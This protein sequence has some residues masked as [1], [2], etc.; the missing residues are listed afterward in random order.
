M[1]ITQDYRVKGN[2]FRLRTFFLVR[3][4]V[5]FLFFP[6]EETHISC[7]HQLWSWVT[8]LMRQT[9]SR[10]QPIYRLEHCSQDHQCLSGESVTCHSRYSDI[11][12]TYPDFPWLLSSKG[13]L[14][15]L[16]VF[17]FALQHKHMYLFVDRICQHLVCFH[18]SWE[19]PG[20]SCIV[21]PIKLKWGTCG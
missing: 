12:L 8:G 19:K 18:S 14:S 1:K 6:L 20:F 15:S 7:L 11:C 13:I 3:G 17:I 2:L 5:F 9:V 21:Y 10:R 4:N 16:L